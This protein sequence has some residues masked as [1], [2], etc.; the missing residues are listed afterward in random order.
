[1]SKKGREGGGRDGKGS[2]PSQHGR[3]DPPSGLTTTCLRKIPSLKSAYGCS[4]TPLKRHTYKQTDTRMCADAQ[5]DGH[6]AEYS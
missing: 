6:P 4:S 5:R 3:L 1:M 2:V